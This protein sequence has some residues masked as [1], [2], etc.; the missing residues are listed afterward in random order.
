ME[1]STE[2]KSMQRKKG[3]KVE[4]KSQVRITRINFKLNENRK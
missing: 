3:A 2:E 4:T 1:G